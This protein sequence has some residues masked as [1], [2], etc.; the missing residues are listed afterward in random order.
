MNGIHAMIEESENTL[1][2]CLLVSD[3][4][5]YGIG[6]LNTNLCCS[7]LGFLSLQIC[8]EYISIV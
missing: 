5:V 8:E 3:G 7:D 1:S 4:P 6:S 2:F